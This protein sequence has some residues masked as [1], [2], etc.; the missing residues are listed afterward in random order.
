ME[1][2]EI[3]LRAELVERHE[4]G[5][6]VACHLRGN[7]RIVGQHEHAEGKR[8]AG[9]LLADPPQSDDSKRL[10]AELGPN[11]AVFLPAT[12]LHPGVSPGD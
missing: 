2:H 1:G 3:R 11:Q 6:Q 8:P 10:P 4:L 12:L 5:A 7:E 9:H